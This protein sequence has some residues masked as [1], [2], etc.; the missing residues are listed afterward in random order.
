LKIFS[1]FCCVDNRP[2]FPYYSLWKLVT[3]GSPYLSA[4]K[5]EQIKENRDSGGCSLPRQPHKKTFCCN[6]DFDSLNDDKF[7]KCSD[8]ILTL[9]NSW[10]VSAKTE[11]S[12]SALSLVSHMQAKLT[13][14][15]V[16]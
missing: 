15:V 9:S 2:L 10:L 14:F 13:F 5:W 3:I 7:G 1:I 6:I 8:D 11:S 4:A 12:S 16:K